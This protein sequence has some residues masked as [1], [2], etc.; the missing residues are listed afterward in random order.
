M[1]WLPFF[2]PVMLPDPQQDQSFGLL[3]LQIRIWKSGLDCER[4]L[5]LL[6]NPAPFGVPEARFN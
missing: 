4:E 3:E 5:D 6:K 1:P 2:L